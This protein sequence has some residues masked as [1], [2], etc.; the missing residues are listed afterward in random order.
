MYLNKQFQKECL[1]F[2]LMPLMGYKH[3]K[4]CEFWYLS[5]YQKSIK[6]YEFKYQ[7]CFTTL[8]FQ[9][10]LIIKYSCPKTFQYTKFY[11]G[12]LCRFTCPQLISTHFF[13]S[14][15]IQEGTFLH[16]K[17]L[18]EHRQLIV[19]IY[20]KDTENCNRVWLKVLVPVWDHFGNKS[21][22]NKI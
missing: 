22:M 11:H 1:I 20:P 18:A 10:S 7:F 2:M 6:F 12:S 17:H 16:R 15:I 5:N 3:T 9:K 8:E 21:I 19:I 4:T 14:F 13:S